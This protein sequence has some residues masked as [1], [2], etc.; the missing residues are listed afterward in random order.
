[1]TQENQPSGLQPAD[2]QRYE[3]FPTELS[4]VEER[5]ETVRRRLRMIGELADKGLY[6][7]TGLGA[8]GALAVLFTTKDPYMSREASRWSTALISS[9][10]LVAMGRGAKWWE[11]FKTRHGSP[12]A[13]VESSESA[14]ELENV[15]VAAADAAQRAY[16]LNLEHLA[17]HP[18][19][20]EMSSTTPEASD[21]QPIDD[22][23]DDEEQ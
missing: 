7:A 9:H 6:L 22:W 13:K 14:V 2:I 19:Q 15:P 10:G 17:E 3:N 5:G 23:Y 21:F 8:V 20:Y 11:E 16:D 18:E 12:A 4:G 1:M